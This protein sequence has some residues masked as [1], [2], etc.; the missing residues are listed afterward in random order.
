MSPWRR[1]PRT[2]SARAATRQ[3]GIGN[4]DGIVFVVDLMAKVGDEPSGEERE[5]AKWAPS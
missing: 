1:P 2:R 4:K 3:L 5:A